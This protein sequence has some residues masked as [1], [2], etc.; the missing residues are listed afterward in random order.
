MG[1]VYRKEF[2]IQHLCRDAAIL[3]K[4]FSGSRDSI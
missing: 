4:S 3:D 1:S 2:A